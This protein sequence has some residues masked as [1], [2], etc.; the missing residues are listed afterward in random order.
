[1]RANR[2]LVMIGIAALVVAVTAIVLQGAN[3]QKPA[4]IM[5]QEP[6]K[7]RSISIVET[8][9][10]RLDSFKNKVNR[11]RVNNGI[12]FNPCLVVYVNDDCRRINVVRQPT[13]AYTL[14]IIQISQENPPLSTMT[15]I[16]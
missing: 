13:R 4:E 6:S 14:R 3:L 5:Q 11:L 9:T 15:I 12:M 7:Q 16:N 10:I 1:M 8:V 2:G